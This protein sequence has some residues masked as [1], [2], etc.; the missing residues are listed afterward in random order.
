MRAG[1]FV[2]CN[3]V[4]RTVLGTYMVINKYLLNDKNVLGLH[5]EPRAV[6]QE[7]SS[8][9]YSVSF[10]MNQLGTRLWEPRG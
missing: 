2:Y 8:S 5:F 6:G 4:P 7:S 3:P 9:H 10:K 1:N